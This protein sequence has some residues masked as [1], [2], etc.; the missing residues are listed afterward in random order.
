MLCFHVFK[1]KSCVFFYQVLGRAG[2]LGGNAAKPSEEV[3]MV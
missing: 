1:A 2:E 3:E